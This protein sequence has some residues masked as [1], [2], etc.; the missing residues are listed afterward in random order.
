VTASK[1]PKSL[2]FCYT[3][4]MKKI[5]IVLSAFILLISGF[6]AFNSYLYNEKQI[7]SSFTADYRQTEFLIDGERMVIGEQLQYFG[8]ELITDLN[9]DGQDDVV[10]LVTHAPGGSGT[11]FYVVAALASE[12]GYVGSDGYLLGDRIAP[13]STHSSQNPRHINAIVVNY[14]DRNPGEPMTTDPSLG[15][16]VYLKIDENN[17]WGIAEADFEGEADPERMTLGMKTWVWQQ[18]L[19]NDGR[20]IVPREIT[21]FTTTLTDVFTITFNDDNSFSATTDCNSIGGTYSISDDL[22]TFS[23]IFST[24]MYCED[25]QEAEFT[26]LLENTSSYSFTNHGELI[27][28]LKYDSGTVTFR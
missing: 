21:I 17:R 22:L 3:V 27:F 15:K 2:V 19:Y 23:D 20:E 4:G 12:E 10:F 6:L 26:S 13:Q 1:A 8:N 18:A 24:L 9:N 14:V 25:A 28:E 16:S 11:F 7:D 5:I